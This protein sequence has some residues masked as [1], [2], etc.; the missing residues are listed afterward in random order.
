MDDK[1]MKFRIILFFE[2]LHA[3]ASHSQF[4]ILLS[5]SS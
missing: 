2:N 1:S 4:K 5:N 3:A